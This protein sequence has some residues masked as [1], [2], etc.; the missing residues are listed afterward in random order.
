MTKVK[1]FITDLGPAGWNQLLPA[2]QPQPVL[3]NDIEADYLIV[4]A[5]FAGLSAAR[6]IMQLDKR[7]NIVL[8]EARQVGGV[9]QDETPVL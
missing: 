8:L 9:L 3:E 2:R 5:G 4:G 6:R 7:A 1:Q